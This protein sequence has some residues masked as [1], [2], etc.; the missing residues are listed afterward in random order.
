MKLGTNQQGVLS[1]LARV[2]K[3]ARGCGW[4]WSTPSATTAIM[5]SLV[6]HGLVARGPVTVMGREVDGYTITEAGRKAIQ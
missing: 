5:E 2:G 3:W 1:S 4:T 6:K